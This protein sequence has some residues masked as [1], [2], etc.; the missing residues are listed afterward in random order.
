MFAFGRCL[1]TSSQ[2]FDDARGRKSATDGLGVGRAIVRGL[3]DAARMQ[4]W[5]HVAVKRNA[6]AL[7]HGE[8]EEQEDEEEVAAAPVDELQRQLTTDEQR[9]LRKQGCVHRDVDYWD[10]NVFTAAYIDALFAGS[11]AGVFAQRAGAPPV[12]PEVPSAAPPQRK[13][14]D[15]DKRVVQL[16]AAAELP[17]LVPADWLV[18]L[19]ELVTAAA[20]PA[21]LVDLLGRWHALIRVTNPKFGLEPLLLLAAYLQTDL[22]RRSDSPLWRPDRC[23]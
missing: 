23:H 21:A 18:D 1:Y 19:A 11:P 6:L 8:E 17:S 13:A 16:E 7:G 14:V 5:Q 15:R 2:F 12:L 22:V 9:H 3:H 20:L 4:H 10:R